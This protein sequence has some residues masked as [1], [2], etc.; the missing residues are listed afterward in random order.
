M[1]KTRVMIA[2]DHAVLREGMRRLLEQEKDI[3]VVGEAS[4]GEEAVRLVDEQKPDVVLMDIVMPKLTGV[5][6]TKLIKKANPA[7]AI[8][9]LTAYSD[10]RYILG[11]LEAGAS[12]YLLKS[13]RSDEIVGAIRAVKSGE[14]VLDS[15]ATRKL[16]ERVVNLSKE[17]PEDKSRGQLS[18]REIE[19][20]RLAARGMS[21]RDIAEK[22]ELSMRTVKAH[23][24]NI[25]NKMRCSSRTEAIVKGFREGY[26]TLD[27]VPQG[28]EGYEKDKI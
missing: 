18:P 1:A 5:E 24:S 2:D 8:L 13:A 3:E 15:M 14:S 6:A 23:L 10:I 21:N 7:T 9:I 17:T 22:L 20:L 27:D 28:I 11:L 4:D 16:L 25:F 12:G 19:I 26:V